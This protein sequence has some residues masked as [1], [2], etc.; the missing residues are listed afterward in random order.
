MKFKYFIVVGE[1]GKMTPQ[2]ASRPT[3]CDRADVILHMNSCD[4]FCKFIF[5]FKGF[6]WL[7][8]ET[9]GFSLLLCVVI[10]IENSPYKQTETHAITLSAVAWQLICVRGLLK[11]GRSGGIGIWNFL[12]LNTIPGKIK[13]WNKSS[14]FLLI[15]NIYLG[16]L[17]HLI[18]D[19][20]NF[21]RKKSSKGNYTVQGNYLVS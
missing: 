10:C 5:Y 16:V 14:F 17:N 6:G 11:W 12:I 4:F 3:A 8:N 20:F 2:L 7:C 15:L 18:T 1:I 13:R 9:K 19:T 21:W